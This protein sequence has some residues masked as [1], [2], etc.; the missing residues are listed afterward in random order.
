MDPRAAEGLGVA[1]A[2]IAALTFLAGAAF[3]P[4]AP[5]GLL[6]VVAAL[7]ALPAAGKAAEL[8]WGRERARRAS[9]LAGGAAML[10]FGGLLVYGGLA[11]S[12]R[13]SGGLPFVSA[14]TNRR[15]GA[16]AF[17]AVGGLLCALGAASMLIGAPGREKGGR[18]P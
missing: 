18:R 16:A 14:R 13:I 10:V 11:P 4:S 3:S 9:P 8:I 1:A 7:F 17:V 6:L 5:R 15:A 12:S 2:S